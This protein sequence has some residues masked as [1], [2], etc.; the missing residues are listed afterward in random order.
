MYFTILHTLSCSFFSISVPVI[1]FLPSPSDLPYSVIV[2][3]VSTQSPI[4]CH[5]LSPHILPLLSIPYLSLPVTH[6]LSLSHTLS[7]S[8]TNSLS[9]LPPC[10]PPFLSASANQLVLASVINLTSQSPFGFISQQLP[11]TVV[12]YPDLHQGS[13]FLLV[14]LLPG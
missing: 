3:C 6:C 9:P 1:N 5:T 11:L 12:L 2:F 10:H 4:P 7:Q 14:L 8:I 13:H